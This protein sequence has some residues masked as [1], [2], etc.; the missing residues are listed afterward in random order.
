MVARRTEE[1]R[2]KKVD[3]SAG[4]AREFIGCTKGVYS[5]TAV[6]FFTVYSCV[7]ALASRDSFPPHAFA[8]SAAR[9]PR[10]SSS[11]NESVPRSIPRRFASRAHHSAPAAP[12]VSARSSAT[13][14]SFL[15]LAS[16]AA[17]AADG[18]SGSP[19]AAA[20]AS[21]AARSAVSSRSASIS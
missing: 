10:V 12:C 3:G 5:K 17:A 1:G 4:G 6:F 13:T 21:E 8:S 20:A 11:S 7:G 16:A 2:V 19:L 15:R 18:G 14:R 9:L